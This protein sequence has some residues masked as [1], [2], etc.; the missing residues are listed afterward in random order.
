MTST[1]Q[2]TRKSAVVTG[3]STGIGEATARQLAAE[4]WKVFAVARRADRLQTLAH[5]TGVTPVAADISNDE[6]VADFEDEGSQGSG[7]DR[8]DA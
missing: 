2:Q 6:D 5:E 7:S 4:G 3:A 8:L 1:T